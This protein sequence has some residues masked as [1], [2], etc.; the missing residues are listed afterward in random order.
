MQAAHPRFHFHEGNWLIRHL[1]ISHL[2]NMNR[3]FRKMVPDPE[4]RLYRRYMARKVARAP[5]STGSHK[6][7]TSFT[8]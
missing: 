4:I 5:T 3:K 7:R 1:A 2:T 8:I 6:V